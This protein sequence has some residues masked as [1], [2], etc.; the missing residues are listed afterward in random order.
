M[1]DQEKSPP[2]D[3][4]ANIKGIGCSFIFMGLLG[5]LFGIG[6]I[7]GIINNLELEFFGI[8]LN[9]QRGQIYWVIGCVA[10]SVIGVMLMRIDKKQPNKLL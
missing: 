3:T 10:F 4:K 2:T 9:N 6:G 5:A 8:E 1:N 7:L